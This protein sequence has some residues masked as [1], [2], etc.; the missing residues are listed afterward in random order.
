MAR[1]YAARLTV[2][3][4]SVTAVTFQASRRRTTSV[5]ASPRLD[6]EHTTSD[7]GAEM[8]NYWDIE[9]HRLL[10]AERRAQ[11][12]G[13]AGTRITPSSPSRG[14]Q[15]WTRARRHIIRSIAFTTT[16]PSTEAQV[17]QTVK[18]TTWADA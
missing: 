16:S 12:V 2:P 13:D 15:R 11:L 4:P 6:G 3:T 8:H 5:L 18:R 10:V 1:S 14:R 9:T 7:K 17:Q